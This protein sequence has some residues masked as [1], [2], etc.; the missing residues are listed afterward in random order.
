VPEVDT[1]QLDATGPWPDGRCGYDGWSCPIH[2]TLNCLVHEAFYSASG[3][4]WTEAPPTAPLGNAAGPACCVRLLH[5]LAQPVVASLLQ[6][7]HYKLAVQVLEA[8]RAVGYRPTVYA[9]A[10]I[11]YFACPDAH[12][13]SR[14]LPRLDPF[15]IYSP[16]S[17]EDCGVP[18]CPRCE[19]RRLRRLV[20]K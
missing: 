7:W 2:R 3:V 5:A 14:V 16:A 17:S 13:S 6:E 19:A 8:L 10:S 9:N 18:L 11:P 15:D 12:F 20:C 4:R 1:S